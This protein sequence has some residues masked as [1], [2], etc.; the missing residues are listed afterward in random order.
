[1][2]EKYLVY[3]GSSYALTLAVL[4]WNVLAPRLRRKQLRRR[5]A[6]TLE[7]IE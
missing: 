7:E 3:I 2:N 4:V 5:L 1:V 6:E